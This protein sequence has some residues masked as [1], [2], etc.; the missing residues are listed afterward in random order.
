MRAIFKKAYPLLYEYAK[1]RYRFVKELSEGFVIRSVGKS[2]RL[3]F[4]VDDFVDW[5]DVDIHPDEVERWL[6]NE[7]YT[8]AVFKNVPQGSKFENVLMGINLKPF[9]KE[10]SKVFY[11]NLEE[12]RNE[13][14]LLK[15]LSRNRRRDL[16]NM[17]NRLDRGGE[18]Y[19]G[20]ENE[21]IHIHLD[22]MASIIASKFRNPLFS[23]KEFVETLKRIC[24]V[25]DVDFWCLRLN[26][27]PIAYSLI[28]KEGE[29]AF[30]WI[31][32]FENEYRYYS[33]AK[34][35]LYKMLLHYMKLRYKEFN[36]MKGES[37]YKGWWTKDFRYIFRYEYLNPSFLRRSISVAVNIVNV[38]KGGR[39][40]SHVK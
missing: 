36:F 7:I 11:I 22:K 13:D 5:W 30:W 31:E 8:Y 14:T 4:A 1:K 28:V 10:A 19:A 40:K 2:L 12:I 20:V 37:G 6:K 38:I 9:K 16:K 34:V 24:N 39:L 21:N 35:L 29:G 32:A 3:H 26:R 23:D 18:W 17:L 33:P 15:S 27:K 25:L